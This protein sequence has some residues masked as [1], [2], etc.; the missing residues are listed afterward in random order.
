MVG[1]LNNIAYF[2]ICNEKLQVIS[3]KYVIINMTALNHSDSFHY[4]LY[5]YTFYNDCT[6]NLQ[7]KEVVVEETDVTVI[8]AGAGCFGFLYGITKQ[9]CNIT[10]NCLEASNDILGRVKHLVFK[11][12][13]YKSG[14]SNRVSHMSLALVDQCAMFFSSKLFLYSLL[15]YYQW[16]IFNDFGGYSNAWRLTYKK[17][18]YNHFGQLIDSKWMDRYIMYTSSMSKC[19]SNE[20]VCNTDDQVVNAFKQLEKLWT[21]LGFIHFKS[22]EKQIKTT[23][24]CVFN[25]Y[26]RLTAD[27][28]GRIGLH[29][30]LE[31][32]TIGQLRLKYFL[33]YIGIIFKLENLWQNLRK[34]VKSKDTFKEFSNYYQNISEYKNIDRLCKLCVSIY[35][36]AKK[37]QTENGMYYEVRELENCNICDNNVSFFLSNIPRDFNFEIIGNI[38]GCCFRWAAIKQFLTDQSESCCKIL[39]VLIPIMIQKSRIRQNDSIVKKYEARVKDAQLRIKNKI[40]QYLEI[41]KLSD[42]FIF[43]LLN[44]LFIY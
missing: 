42:C 33:E 44:L 29:S 2:N 14:I 9:K 13:I 19:L 25:L 39:F 11:P 15:S 32:V 3:S 1:W 28:T 34:I 38:K 18:H 24:H 41:E 20:F 7:N 12:R 8:G 40:I 23:W 16:K 36:A 30:Y 4:E 6:L 10:V 37:R 43:I 17:H 31:Q 5:D 35:S 22:N 26:L 21:K 27:W